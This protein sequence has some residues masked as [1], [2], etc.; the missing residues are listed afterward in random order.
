[1]SLSDIKQKLLQN[2]K[3]EIY[4]E[5]NREIIQEEFLKP[6]IETILNEMYP[7]FMWMGLFFF[8]MFVF[9]ILILVLNVRIFFIG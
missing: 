1:M 7:Y 4:T 3:D 9:I 6:M 8:S 5:E 2:I